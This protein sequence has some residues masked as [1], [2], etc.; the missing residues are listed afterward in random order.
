[1]FMQNNYLSNDTVYR[2]SF[3]KSPVDIFHILTSIAWFHLDTIGRQ[4]EC[5]KIQDQLIPIEA[6]TVCPVFHPED[7]VPGTEVIGPD[8]CCPGCIPITKPCNVTKSKVYLD[9]N[10]CKS[11][12]TV[13]VTTCSGS[14]VTYAM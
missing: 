4:Y 10:G 5:V 1:S 13:E 7:C 3:E 11:A 2:I 12:N 8:G 14:C 9:S 6:K